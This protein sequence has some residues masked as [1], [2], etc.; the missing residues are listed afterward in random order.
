MCLDIP[1]DSGKR[2]SEASS[3]RTAHIGDDLLQF[4]IPFA[5]LICDQAWQGA[6]RLV[7]SS[8]IHL[9]TDY[10]QLQSN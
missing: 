8:P 2:P 4:Y 3:H 9:M 10:Q 7:H 5:V 1:P 6:Q